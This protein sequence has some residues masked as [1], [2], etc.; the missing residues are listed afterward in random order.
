MKKLLAQ[1]YVICNISGLI[2]YILSVIVESIIV[3]DLPKKVYFENAENAMARYRTR[4]TIQATTIVVLWAYLLTVG[5]SLAH[6]LRDLE[7]QQGA[8]VMGQPAGAPLVAQM[9]NNAYASGS[10]NEPADGDAAG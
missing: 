5:A 10:D 7:R 6:Y 9:T 3:H 1:T 4:Q 2:S 8:V